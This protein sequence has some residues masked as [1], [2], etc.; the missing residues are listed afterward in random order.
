MAASKIFFMK[1]DG[2]Q[3]IRERCPYMDSS[4]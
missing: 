3:Q 2:I 4:L 1:Q